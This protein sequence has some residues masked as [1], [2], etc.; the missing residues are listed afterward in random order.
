M[1]GLKI[2]EG[3]ITAVVRV[4]V[5][6]DETAGSAGSNSHAR[7]RPPIPPLGDLFGLRGRRL[8]AIRRPWVLADRRAVCAPARASDTMTL[9]VHRLVNGEDR[10]AAMRVHESCVDRS[11]AAGIHRSIPASSGPAF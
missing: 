2:G 3:V 5:H 10:P 11:S 4:D 6:N 8:E 9:G 1:L 7:I